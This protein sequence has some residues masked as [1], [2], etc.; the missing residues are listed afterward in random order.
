MRAKYEP[1]LAIFAIEMC[2]I[3]T[4]RT[5]Q[6]QTCSNAHLPL[7][8]WWQQICSTSVLP[9][10]RCSHLKCARLWSWPLESTK[11]KFKYAIRMDTRA[12]TCTGNCYVCRYRHRLSL[13]DN[14]VRTS[15]CT[16][17]ASC[18][19][20]LRLYTLTILMILGRQT[21]IVK[22]HCANLALPDQAVCSRY[23]SSRTYVRADDHTAR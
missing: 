13:R 8:I 20:K 17:F 18:H 12:S 5:G 3:V 11:V 14:D 16:R 22:T 7:H 15:R 6:G 19:W 9:F 4:L 10:A 23:I 21:Y 1:I 2:L